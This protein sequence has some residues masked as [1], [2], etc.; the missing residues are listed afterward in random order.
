MTQKTRGVREDKWPIEDLVLAGL[1]YHPLAYYPGH[2]FIFVCEIQPHSERVS[3]RCC[4]FESVVRWLA[5]E[6]LSQRRAFALL[7]HQPD[8]GWYLIDHGNVGGDPIEV[9]RLLGEI[10]RSAKVTS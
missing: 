4:E 1:K 6:C 9:I 5:S 3:V 8:S 10:S 2:E 7:R